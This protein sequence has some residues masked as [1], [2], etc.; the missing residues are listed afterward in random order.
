MSKE[1]KKQV[2]KWQ[3]VFSFGRDFRTMERGWKQV[4]FGVFNIHRLPEA[5]MMLHKGFYQG[6]ILRFYIWL[7]VDF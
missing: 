5:G 1:I 2:N 4:V 3:L 6:F 7:P